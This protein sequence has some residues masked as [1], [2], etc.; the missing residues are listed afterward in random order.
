MWRK[1]F[2][3]KYIPDKFSKREKLYLTLIIFLGTA[4]RILYQHNRAFLDDEIGTIIYLGRD[5]HYLLSHFTT[6]LTM[7]YFIIIEKPFARLFGTGIFS[8]GFLP[9]LAGILAIPLTAYLA[10]RFTSSKASMI[11]AILVAFNPYLIKFSGTVRSYSILVA[12]SLLSIILFFKWREGRNYKNGLLFAFSCYLMILAHPNGIF[13]LTFILFLLA[14]ETIVRYRERDFFQTS[15]TLLIPL[16]I[17][18]ILICI[19]YLKIFPEMLRDGA[20][21]HD[22]P[23]TSINYIPYTFTEYFSSGFLAWI[24]LLF[25]LTGILGIFKNSRPLLI[26]LPGIFIPIIIISAQGLSHFPWAYS[27][28][29]IPILPLLIIFIT[30]GII[31]ITKYFTPENTTFLTI[32][33]IT[34]LILSWGPQLINIFSTKTDFPWHIA[35]DFIKSQY[36]QGDRILCCDWLDQFHLKPYL[37]ETEYITA[38]LIDYDQ[39]DD[40]KNTNNK[41]LLVTSSAKQIKTD[42]LKHIFGK[43]QIAIYPCLDN[44]IIYRIRNDI[45]DSISQGEIDPDLTPLYRCI[46]ELNKKLGINKDTF[47]YYNLYIKSLFLT[48][49]KRYIPAKLQLYEFELQR[50]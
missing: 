22:I 12:L 21:W 25:L 50:L 30:E 36:N 19:S 5:I 48:K 2:I 47:K 9:L 14:L 10:I 26:L 29:L 43:I 4:I 20:K 13:I 18:I 33:L 16:L 23:P 38:H 34:V 28:F 37:S 1:Y 11:A 41:I 31:Y 42:Y 17:I 44:H 32:A 8:L 46:F 35:A 15:R 45:L 3:T 49:R 7:N 39:N 27:R 6:W 24:T 40:Q